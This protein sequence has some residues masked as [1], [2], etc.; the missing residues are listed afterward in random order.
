MDT[1]SAMKFDYSIKTEDRFAFRKWLQNWINQFEKKPL[2]HIDLCL[3]KDFVGA[4]FADHELNAEQFT[5]LMAKLAHPKKVVMVRMPDVEVTNNDFLFHA[6]GTLEIYV[7]KLVCFDGDFVCKVKAVD[8]SFEFVQ[9]T[10]YPRMTMRVE[11]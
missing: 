11:L 3:A 10:F 7:D 2:P 6:K 4:G 8:D 5:S 9:M 1:E